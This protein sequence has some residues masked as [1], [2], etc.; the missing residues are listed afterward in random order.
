MKHINVVGAVLA[1]SLSFVSLHA[2]AADASVAKEGVVVQV[3]D[4]DPAKW[5]LA[6]NNVKN[7]QQMLGADKVNAE[8]VVYGPGIAMLKMDSAVAGRIEEAKKANITIVACENTMKGMKLT[9]EDMLPNTSYV[10]AGVVELMK[11][12]KEGYAYIRP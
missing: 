6:L 10:P 11:K 8:I 4:A 7:V 12:Q 3:S 9:K 5:N 1:L 2:A